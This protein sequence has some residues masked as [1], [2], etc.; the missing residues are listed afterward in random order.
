MCYLT[1]PNRVTKIKSNTSTSKRVPGAVV[2]DH[3]GPRGSVHRGTGSRDPPARS[4]Q[5][6][7]QWRHGSGV[8][9][10]TSFEDDDD[11][12]DLDP[13]QACRGTHTTKRIPLSGRGVKKYSAAACLPSPSRRRSCLRIYC[14]VCCGIADEDIIAPH[15]RLRVDSTTFLVVDSPGLSL[16][17]LFVSFLFPSIETGSGD[18]KHMSIK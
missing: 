3:R 10:D 17:S 13:K 12:D 6:S 18:T 16:V 5:G 7:W 2:D 1:I 4:E 9:R 15:R 14:L 8:G 11:D